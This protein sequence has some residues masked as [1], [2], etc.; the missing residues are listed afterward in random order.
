MEN[1]I[2]SNNA[3]NAPS[4]K[5]KSQAH[6]FVVH[7]SITVLMIK[8]I[9]FQQKLNLED[10]FVITRASVYEQ[11]VKFI[12]HEQVL[13]SDGFYKY[14]NYGNKGV[15]SNLSLVDRAT[16]IRGLY[17]HIGL[18]INRQDYQNKLQPL[19][20]K[21]EEG[22]PAFYT[23][24]TD[25]FGRDY[26]LY[27]PHLSDIFFTYLAVHR[28]CKELNFFEEGTLNYL[29]ILHLNG[30]SVKTA[31]E[32]ELNPAYGFAYTGVDVLKSY[33]SYSLDESPNPYIDP[34]GT[35]FFVLSNVAF[36]YIAASDSRKVVIETSSLHHDDY[37]SLLTLRQEKAYKEHV[38]L[39]DNETL[40]R[41]IKDKN[42][43]QAYVNLII[44][45]GIGNTYNPEKFI[46]YHLELFR[47][48]RALGVVYAQYKFHPRLSQKLRGELRK[49]LQ[50]L[51]MVLEEI[52]DNISLENEFINSPPKTFIVHAMQ[53]STLL[54]A[55]CLDQFAVCHQS[56]LDN[57]PYSAILKRENGFDMQM[58]TSKVAKNHLNIN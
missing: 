36:S 26:S 45:E 3:T 23:D 20:I 56:I 49:H 9:M 47:K 37:K 14:E 39:S 28:N 27:V 6:I 24:Q 50:N 8:F 35:Y 53:S 1:T 5:N 13:I 11:V 17:D 40:Q 29:N 22:T 33:Q 15:F 55:G 12:P 19:P 38:L 42:N 25:F 54:Y 4:K 44:L 21:V 34:E 32:L 10:V 43:I 18:L 57:D 58:L 7:S 48:V 51:D 16:A 31:N 2:T 30:I 46:E 52:A 41:Y